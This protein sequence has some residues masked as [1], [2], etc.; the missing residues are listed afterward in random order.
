MMKSSV[1]S[2]TNDGSRDYE[3]H[4]NWTNFDKEP[5]IPGL[6]NIAV[7]RRGEVYVLSR[8]EPCVR[9]FDAQGQ[10][11][12]SW[13]HRLMQPPP[14]ANGFGSA[15]GI[16]VSD[17]EHLYITTWDY[18]QVLKFTREG[19]LLLELGTHGK[20]RWAAPF[21][22][23]TD[24]TLSSDNEIYVSDGYGNARIHR[25]TAEGELMQSWGGPG[26]GDGQ[27][28]CPHAIVVTS[29][30]RVIV[31]DRDNDRLQVFGR[32]GE[33]LDIWYGY[34]KPMS[35]WTI[36]DDLFVADQT[37]RISRISLSTGKIAGA[38]RSISGLIPHG[39]SGDIDGSL[40]V[41]DM[42]PFS[43]ITKYEAGIQADENSDELP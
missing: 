27:F 12:D 22:H 10:E 1:P 4:L 19:K 37:P 29:D 11:V 6:C 41:A 35:L 26:V 20:A 14:H 7:S 3:V 43:L 40:F 31:A 34:S 39:I 32:E 36:D 16:Y 5:G 2:S 25:F 28:A 13:T 8:S 18:H 33:L 21:N 17:E 42:V 15:H 24:V 30:D 23:P 38:F 9:I